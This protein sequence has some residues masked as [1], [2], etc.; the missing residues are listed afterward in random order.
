M[1]QSNDDPAS[2]AN[3]KHEKMTRG[4]SRCWLRHVPDSSTSVAPDF[5]E[6]SRDLTPPLL[7]CVLETLQNG[8]HR[9]PPMNEHVAIRICMSSR[10]LCA[11]AC[12]RD[13]ALNE[14]GTAQPVGQD[15]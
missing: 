10:E 7:T 6:Q 13:R 15:R 1:R 4:T 2:Q 5:P 14:T 9:T 3:G 12:F 8:R 11:D